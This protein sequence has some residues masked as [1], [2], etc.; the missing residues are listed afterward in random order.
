MDIALYHL[1]AL[2]KAF[3]KPRLSNIP[4]TNINRFCEATFEFAL[5]NALYTRLILKLT[6]NQDYHLYFKR[7]FLSLLAITALICY[8]K[9][10]R[11]KAIVRV[12]NVDKDSLLTRYLVYSYYILSIVLTFIF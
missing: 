9:G 2:F 1:A 4:Y 3:R 10:K 12:M 8:L 6:N 7:I 5:G 11:I